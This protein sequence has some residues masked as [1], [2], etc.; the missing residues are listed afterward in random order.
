LAADYLYADLFIHPIRQSF[1]ESIIKRT[2]PSYDM[3]VFRNF[4]SC[5]NSKS[6]TSLKKILEVSENFGLSVDIPLFSAYFAKKT[7]NSKLIIEAAYNEKQ[8][9]YFKDARAKLSELN[10]FLDNKER[11]KHLREINLLKSDLEKTFKNI[12]SKYGLGDK[13]G[14]GIK[15]FK[16]LFS[17]IPILKN[18]SLPKELD[19]R[20]KKLEFM[21]HILPRK[22]FNAVYTNVIEELLEF[23]KIGKY[24]DILVGNVKYDKDAVFWDIKTE[25]FQYMN[26]SSYWKKPM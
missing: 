3:G 10:L 23:E 12:E 26:A 17:S 11:Y 7:G 6:E 16:F 5:I 8:K 14:V 15:E 1:L 2:H 20:I 24:K 9:S 21:K 22:G 25:D 18:F 13:Q 19:I 4:F